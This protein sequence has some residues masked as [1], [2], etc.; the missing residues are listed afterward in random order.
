MAWAASHIST[1]ETVEIFN[2]LPLGSVLEG[3]SVRSLEIGLMVISPP[4]GC[5]TSAV[6][7]AK[8]VRIELEKKLKLFGFYFGNSPGVMAHVFELTKEFHAKI[9]MLFHLHEAGLRC[10]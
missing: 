4:N 2:D 9:W 10:L 7:S 3:L 5:V 8:G 6:I 1:T